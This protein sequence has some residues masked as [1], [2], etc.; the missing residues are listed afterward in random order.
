M[1]NSRY[2]ISIACLTLTALFLSLNHLRADNPKPAPEKQISYYNQIRPIFQARCQGCHQPAKDKGKYDM[3][4]FARLLKGGDSGDPAITPH[5]PDKSALIDLVLPLNGKAEMPK[6]RKPLH[7]TEIE[8]IEKWI[9]QGAKDD[10]PPNAREKYSLQNPPVYSRQPVI[11]SLDFSP[12]GKQLAVS[13]FHEV[14]LI[15]TESGQLEARLIGLAERIQAIAYSPNGQQIAV[16]GGLPGRMGEIQVWDLKENKLTL[17]HPVTYETLNG[18]SWSPDGQLI[19]FGCA[20]N[21]V[22][23]INAK[24]GEQVLFQGAHNDWIL[25]TVFSVDGKYVVSV[26]RDMTAKLTEVKTQR[27]IDNIT[28]IT[29]GALKGGI[30]AVARHPERNEIVIGS[31]DGSVKVY[32][33]ERITKRVIGDDANQIRT[34]PQMQGRVFD[35]AV[36]NDG[37]RIAS[38]SSLDGHGQLSVF[39][40]E[41][42]TTMPDNIKKI[43]TKVVTQRNANEKKTLADYRSKDV[44]QIS[45][46]KLDQSSLYALAF[47]PDNQTLAIAGADGRIRLVEASSGSVLREIQPAPVNKDQLAKTIAAEKA[48]RIDFIQDVNPV[49]SKLGCNQGTCHGADKGKN[50]FKLSLRGYDAIFDIRSLTD[51]HASRRVNI[52]SPD[53]S[54]MLLKATGAV[55]H[56]GD[57]LIKPDDKYYNIIREWIAAGAKLN[58]DAPRVAN[59]ELS[60]SN[61]VLQNPKDQQPMKVIATYTDG[62]K[63]NVTSEAFIDT[64]NGEVATASKKGIMTAVRRGEAPVIA[65]YE[66]AYAATTLTIMGDRSGFKWQEPEKWSTIDELVAQKWQ[67]MKILPSQLST[68]EEFLRRVYLDL[69]GLPPTPEQTKAFLADTRDSKIKRTELIDKLVGNPD[70]IDF[71]TNKWSDLLQVN[72]K[73]LGREGATLFRD[74]IRKQ[75]ETNTPYNQFVSEIITATGSNKTNP[76][77]S[78]YKILRTPEDIMENTTHLFL[79]VRFNCNKC[80]DHPFERW[81]QDQ[82][83]NL[84]AYFSQTNLKRDPVHGKK[85]IGGTAVEGAKPL[86]EIVEDTNAG[87]MKHVRTG[88]PVEPEFPYDCKFE[89]PAEKPTRRQQLAAW[90]TSPDN[91]Y[92]ARSYVNRLWGYL[93]GVGIIEPIDDIRAGNPPTNPELLDY[94]TKEFINSNFNT[95]HV[96]KLIC[97]S[98]TY[99]LSFRSNKWNADDKLNYSHAQPRR[100]PAEVLYDAIYRTTGATPNFPGVPKGTRAAALPDVGIKLPSGFLDTFGRP[101]RESAC[102][103]ERSNDVQLGSVMAMISGPA[104]AKA[105]ADPNNA[106]AK[107]TSEIKDDKQLINAVYLRILNRHATDQEVNTV[108]GT[109]KLIEQD[110]QALIAARDQR[111]KVA[112]D[113]RRKKEDARLEALAKAKADF[114]AYQQKIA[115]DLAK[116][117]EAR[118][119]NIAKQQQA[120]DA[121]L[122]QIADKQSAWEAQQQAIAWQVLQ[123]DSATAYN[124]AKLTPNKDGSITAELK[125]TANLYT[126]TTKTKADNITAIRLE[127]LADPKLP[128][129]GPGL[130]A[131]NGNFVLTEFEVFAAPI[132]NPKQQTKLKLTKPMSDFNQGGYPIATVLDDK[133]P[134]AN[135][136]WAIAG[137]QG[138]THW[139]TFQLDKPLPNKEG[140]ILTFKLDQRYQDNQHQLGKFR[141]SLSTHDQPVGLSLPHSVASVLTT[142]KDKRTEQQNKTLTDFFSRTDNQL[143]TLRTNLSNAQKPLPTDP[144]ITQRQQAIKRLE[145]PTPPDALLAQL[146]ATLKI[147]EQQLNNK[148]LTMAQDLAWALLNSPAFLFNH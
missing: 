117:E 2:K 56:E 24:S 126:V 7:E 143:A 70:Y 21:T 148:R 64:G 76:A 121:Y 49:L 53:N 106:L 144:G 40:Y 91:P 61:P 79:G 98:R 85:N 16:A 119:T 74:W 78:Y 87:Q 124:K 105:I 132:S 32:R 136:G 6:D 111:Q 8:L 52:A 116:K 77:A 18:V 57:Q 90:M 38:V 47:H 10:T 31:S 92:F 72:G 81:T 125:K 140:I 42:D 35:V 107:L 95:Q 9:A 75:I 37:K 118:Q 94:L 135:N 130:S 97:K 54:L 83:F 141:L 100:L 146:N 25:D 48:N 110:H 73:F 17:S 65:R 28:S 109:Q 5:H 51:D 120:L 60:P 93:T 68:E 50:G 4:T 123:P 145:Q 11:S 23:A 46:L 29:P 27:F 13:G 108:L 103:C 12:S 1:I 45:T 114:T 36:S 99:Q 19:A 122:T 15:N 128:G 96:V 84:A 112:A 86:Y 101:A 59:I 131:N 63:R 89:T 30:Q 115:P 71:W 3:T 66:G 137:Q 102:E 82:Y 14:L 20:D 34:L 139:A 41:F 147:S 58:L 22:R 69:T 33:M 39:G 129:K 142:P 80:H 55:P 44:K 134:R 127:A 67:R 104:V 133:R 88:N 43:V 62:T 113:I 138:R 26:G